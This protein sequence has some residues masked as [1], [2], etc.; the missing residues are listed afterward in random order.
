MSDNSH[1][2]EKLALRRM[3]IEKYHARDAR[4][5]DC[6]QGDGVIWRQLRKEYRIDGYW[7]VDLKEKRGRLK[8][9]S[10]R[11]LAMGIRE[12]I[13]DID[14]YGSP[15]R[16]WLLML[17]TIREPK[18]VFLTIYTKAFKRALSK[19]EAFSL[20]LGKHKHIVRLFGHKLTSV[21]PRYCLAECYKY[22]VKIIDAAQ[23]NHNDINYIGVRI[24]RERTEA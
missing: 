16:H 21:A 6:C 14:V 1:I 5:F 19:E 10:S 7:G 17:P 23:Y 3:L 15:W 11:I 24:E 18:T 2:D 9:D 22:G 20:G 8:I 4:V 12:N 13:V